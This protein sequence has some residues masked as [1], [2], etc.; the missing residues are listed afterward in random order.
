MSFTQIS[1]LFI[2]CSIKFNSYKSAYASMHA[3]FYWK[4]KIFRKIKLYI[5]HLFMSCVKKH[6][7]D[8]SREKKMN[9]G[10]V[11]EIKL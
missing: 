11:S 8:T 1:H 3:H 9:R 7:L 5:N 2:F 10:Q 6:V 4:K